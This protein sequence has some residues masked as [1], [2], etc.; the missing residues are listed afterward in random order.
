MKKTHYKQIG[1]SC[2]R[3]GKDH[4]MCTWRMC[5]CECKHTVA[6]RKKLAAKLAKEAKIQ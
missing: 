5:D 4:E 1:P 6:G 2:Q 3:G